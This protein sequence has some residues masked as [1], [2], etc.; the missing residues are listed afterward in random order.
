MDVVAIDPIVV[1]LV[2]VVVLVAVVLVTGRWWQG[3]DGRVSASTDGQGRV[4]D[5]RHLDAVGLD[6]SDARAGVVLIGSPTCAPC[7][8][9]K[10]VLSDLQRERDGLRWV[11]ADAAD[12][13]ELTAQHRILRVPTLLIV[14]PDGRVVARSSGVPRADELRRTIDDQLGL[15]A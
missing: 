8:T 11:Y 6:L 13:V 10:D 14:A 4:V 15:A 7:D 5:R 1:R 3:R 2:L 12:H 9:A